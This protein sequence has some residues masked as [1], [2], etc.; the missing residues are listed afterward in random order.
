MSS[1]VLYC[2]MPI[3]I[4][5]MM[6]ALS[7]DAYKKNIGEVENVWYW[8]KSKKI[9]WVFAFAVNIILVYSLLSTQKIHIEKGLNKPKNDVQNVAKD[10]IQ[11]NSDTLNIDYNSERFITH[12]TLTTY[13][14]VKEQCDSN[15]LVTADGTKIDLH[16]LKK[17]EIKYCAVSQDLL[18]CLPFKTRLYIE[19]HGVYEVRDTMNKRFNRCI[20]ILQHTDEKNFKKSKIKVIRLD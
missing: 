8:V 15:P 5:F 13:N 17:G 7:V 4:C 14:P 16:K 2:V 1:F 12:V 10:S 19:G 18:W 3:F 20:D 9:T 11:A 6:M